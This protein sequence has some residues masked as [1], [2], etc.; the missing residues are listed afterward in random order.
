[1]RAGDDH[2]DR[3]GGVA[4]EVAV[5]G[6]AGL[7]ALGRGGQRTGVDAAEGDVAERQAPRDQR[8]PAHPHGSHRAPHPPAPHPGPRTGPRR[9]RGA[10]GRRPR[11]RPPRRTGGP[12]PASP[13]GSPP[14]APT[15]APSPAAMPPKAMERRNISGN[16]SKPASEIATV[17][18]EK[19]TVRPAVATVRASAS[20][21]PERP[22]G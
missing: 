15:I 22:A 1:V 11:G 4:G 3:G 19:Q 2:G 13:A 17:S 16:I 10:R 21:T 5:Q 7:A 6:L 8:P 12:A 9:P 14:S 20:S 18:P